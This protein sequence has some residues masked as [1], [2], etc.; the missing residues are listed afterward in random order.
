MN[1]LDVIEDESSH[2]AET[3]ATRYGNSDGRKVDNGHG[4]WQFNGYA[5][6]HVEREK[7]QKRGG[8]QLNSKE[9]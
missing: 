9:W 2:V 4:G 8:K 3:K 6:A 7:S 1:K 5:N